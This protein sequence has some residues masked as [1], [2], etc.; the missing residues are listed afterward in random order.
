[1]CVCVCGKN[2]LDLFRWNITIY[3]DNDID[4]NEV[5]Y[6]FVVVVVVVEINND[7]PF[8]MD[9]SRTTTTTTTRIK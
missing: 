8:S 1:M 6:K 2:I 5:P 9:D 3:D 4:H 7:F